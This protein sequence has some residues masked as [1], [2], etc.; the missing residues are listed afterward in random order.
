MTTPRPLMF[1]ELAPYYDRLLEGKDYRSEV[2]RLEELAR[3]YSRSSGTSWLRSLT[4]EARRSAMLLSLFPRSALATRRAVRPK[5]WRT[6]RTCS[7]GHFVLPRAE[8][9]G[10]PLGV[11]SRLASGIAM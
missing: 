6:W 3:R 8:R 11:R 4:G 2:R 5:S 9:R 7:N 10:V 1:Y